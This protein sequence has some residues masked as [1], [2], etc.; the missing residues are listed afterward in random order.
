MRMGRGLLTYIQRGF[1]NSWTLLTA[2]Y[3]FFRR[4]FEGS[5][6]LTIVCAPPHAKVLN[7]R[8]LLLAYVYK[9]VM[10]CI[11]IYVI[12]IMWILD[13]PGDC[14]MPWA[15]RSQLPL[16]LCDS[17]TKLHWTQQFERQAYLQHWSIVCLYINRRCMICVDVLAKVWDFCVVNC[18]VVTCAGIHPQ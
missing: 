14:T 9:Y 4:F 18:R 17:F 8:A 12:A 15:L 3:I 5:I 2:S 1:S 6:F 10:P 13:W 7:V 11:N 16:N